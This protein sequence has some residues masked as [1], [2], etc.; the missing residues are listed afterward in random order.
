MVDGGG[1]FHREEEEEDADW[2][3]RQL[4]DVLPIS[5]VAWEIG[6]CSSLRLI[7]AWG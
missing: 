1:R 2:D 6:Y 3:E 5:V 7:S 4:D